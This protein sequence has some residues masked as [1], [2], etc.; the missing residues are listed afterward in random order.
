MDEMLSSL[1]DESQQ[2]EI[3]G[4]NFAERYFVGV[5]RNAVDWWIANPDAWRGVL[6]NIAEQEL[7]DFLSYFSSRRPRVR[8]GYA[9]AQDPMPQINV[10]LESARLKEQFVGDLA[11]MGSFV[12]SPANGGAINGDIRQQSIS[13]HVHAD[14]PEITLYLYHMVHASLLSSARFFAEKEILNLS[15]DSATELQP[16]EVY[17][18]ENI[19]SRA[20]TYTF[21]GVSRGI[22]PL[23]A[24]PPELFIF[25]SGVRINDTVVGGVT[26]TN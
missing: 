24:P 23:P 11:Y 3:S 7:Q 17:L 21:D 20:L 5:L 12:E 4:I 9:R 26:P 19:Y 14:H 2:N 10:I 1:L 13:I 18:P 16:Q 8:L 15:F 25:V 6:G 22:I